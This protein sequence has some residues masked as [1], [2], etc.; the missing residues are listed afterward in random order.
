MGFIAEG[1]LCFTSGKMQPKTVI[2]RIVGWLV[3]VSGD[4]SIDSGQSGSVNAPLIT[5]SRVG[6][7]QHS[8]NLT[9]VSN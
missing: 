6:C 4:Q 7:K 9:L 8:K 2:W 3:Q 5:T 1:E